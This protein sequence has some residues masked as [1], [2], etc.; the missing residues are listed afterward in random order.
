MDIFLQ[1]QKGI[2]ITFRLPQKCQTSPQE[3]A[4]S[5]AR[6]CTWA[7]VWT[8]Q[9]PNLLHTVFL[10]LSCADMAMVKLHSMWCYSQWP[11]ASAE[12][13]AKIGGGHGNSPCMSSLIGHSA[14]ECAK[15]LSPDVVRKTQTAYCLHPVLK[16]LHVFISQ[17]LAEMIYVY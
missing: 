11:R 5:W 14:E 15:I 17:H 3:A 8:Y 2:Y 4:R 12:D 7:M 16:C 1:G 13:V 6:E 10:L 9:L